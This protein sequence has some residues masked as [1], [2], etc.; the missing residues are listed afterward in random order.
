MKV[1]IGSGTKVH[2]TLCNIL[3]IEWNR[4]NM[5][6]LKDLFCVEL[7]LFIKGLCG[8]IRLSFLFLFK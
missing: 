3:Q 1:N 2:D 6:K 7:D 8:S 4:K 5:C